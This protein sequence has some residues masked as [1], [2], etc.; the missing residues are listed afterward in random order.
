MRVKNQPAS[1]MYRTASERPQSSRCRRRGRR[2]GSRASPRRR[3]TAAAGVRDVLHPGRQRRER[4]EDARERREHRRDRPDEPL[5]RRAVPQDH[6]DREDAQRDAEQ[7]Q[8]QQE[9]DQQPG[10]TTKK[11]RPKT[12]I[13]RT[14]ITTR[15]IE[16]VTM[17]R[18]HQAARGTPRSTAAWRTGSGS[19]A[20]RRPRGTSSSRRASRG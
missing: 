3:T 4:V 16:L 20:T 19:C 13:A 14:S 11:D 5:G 17:L 9:R 12:T 8:H 7:E 2:R 1:R 10:R 6:G 15:P 18:D